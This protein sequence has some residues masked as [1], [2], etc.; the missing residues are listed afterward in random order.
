MALSPAT[1]SFERSARKAP[2]RPTPHTRFARRMASRKRSSG[3]VRFPSV[4]NMTNSLQETVRKKGVDTRGYP[5]SR[6]HPLGEPLPVKN[7][8]VGKSAM[9]PRRRQD[10]RPQHQQEKHDGQGENPAA[11]S[12]VRL[13][14]DE[15][16]RGKTEVHREQ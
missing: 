9:G 3:R 12:H 5:D 1:R 11:A 14:V 8:Q 6:L 10:R 16:L 2:M 13:A 7:Q 4:F 15:P